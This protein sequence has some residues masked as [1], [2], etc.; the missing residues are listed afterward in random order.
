MIDLPSTIT[1]WIA[2]VTAL[3]L[4]IA[5]FVY[6]LRRN[7]LQ[8]LRDS[9]SDLTKRVEFLEKEN[10]RLDTAYK[11]VKFKKDYLKSIVIQALSQKASIDQ[12]LSDEIKDH[13][14]I[15]VKK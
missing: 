1:G 11:D 7:D 13:L 9:I 2:V 5:F 8:L 15:V 12:S 14:E 4:G 6:Q 10:N 3:G